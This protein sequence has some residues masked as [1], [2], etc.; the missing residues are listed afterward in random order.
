[1]A[2]RDPHAAHDP[3]LV[4]ALVEP[5]V[6][7][8][9][10]GPARGW[11]DDCPDCATLYHDLLALSM[12]TRALPPEPRSRD[13]R[14]SAPDAARLTEAA[15]RHARHDPAM[16]SALVDRS[17]DPSDRSAGEAMVA[18]C[19]D[20]ASLFE[21]L[22]VLAAAVESMPTPA[23]PREYVLSVDDAA[24]IR[25]PGWRR[26][27][28]GL[29]SPGDALSRPLAIGLTT[30]GLVGILV[31]GV[32]SIMPV[33]SAASILQTVGSPIDTGAAEAARLP[34]DTAATSVPERYAPA[35]G[36]LASVLPDTAGD[37][38]QPGALTG[39]A[40]ASAAPASAAPTQPTDLAANPLADATS[41]SVAG[42][43]IDGSRELSVGAPAP[44]IDPVDA[45]DARA[46]LLSTLF[47]VIGLGLFLLRWLVRRF[48]AT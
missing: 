39:A 16:V 9:G 41:P 36:P 4:A 37:T 18:A 43:E 31:V 34:A 29:G 14:I 25:R 6:A 24:R 32:P 2:E 38:D 30:M 19:A 5:P 33:G 46:L 11:I 44:V 21:D 1:M 13:F 42:A 7:D 12:A 40:A 20:C 28:G 48:A 17:A 8:L 23:R 26:I 47:L 45:G 22:S 3:L 10:D 15:A 35:A 27:L